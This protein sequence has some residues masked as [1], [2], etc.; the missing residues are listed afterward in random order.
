M[1]SRFKDDVEAFYKKVIDSLGEAEK[2]LYEKNPNNGLNVNI[3][4][5]N[6]IHKFSSEYTSQHEKMRES[7]KKIT[8][9]KEVTTFE[10]K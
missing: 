4:T 8:A 9:D 6:V 7:L 5:S 3:S 2:V 1:I 10:L